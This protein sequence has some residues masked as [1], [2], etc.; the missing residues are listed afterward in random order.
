MSEQFR[1]DRIRRALDAASGQ[2]HGNEFLDFFVTQVDRIAHEILHEGRKI[3]ETRQAQDS[4][5]LFSLIGHRFFHELHVCRQ[6]QAI[7]PAVAESFIIRQHIAHTVDHRRP[8]LGNSDAG[9][10]RPI[11]QVFPD[12][13]RNIAFEVRQVDAEET[14]SLFRPDIAH[15]RRCRRHI[16]FDSVGQS[17]NGRINRNRFRDAFRKSR[18]HKGIRRENER[19]VDR[20]LGPG[21]GIRQD[22]DLGHFTARPSCRRYGNNG[23]RLAVRS[24]EQ[25]FIIQLIRADQG[26]GLSRIHRRTAANTDDEIDTLFRS[27]GSGLANRRHRRIIFDLIKKEPGN[28]QFIQ[29]FHD[30]RLRTIDLGRMTACD[31]QRF[32]SQVSQHLAR[33]GHAGLSK[34]YLRRHIIRKHEDS[35]FTAQTV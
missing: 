1:R 15:G 29:L 8:R 13:R 5:D 30:S 33:L 35:P 25:M 2:S 3:V 18:I 7:G 24:R 20:L 16:A 26:D 28:P 10:G 22:T 31:Q 11:E 23:Q 21:L 14:H 6:E 34:K 32:P 12:D 19:R 17:I 27:K 9:Q 4:P